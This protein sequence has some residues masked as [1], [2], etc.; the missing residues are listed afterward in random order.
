MEIK[1]IFILLIIILNILV[2]QPETA[3]ARGIIIADDRGILETFRDDNQN[4]ILD[5]AQAVSEYEQVILHLGAQKVFS[6]G[7]PF[8]SRNSQNNLVLFA[9]EMQKQDQNFYLWFMD[10]FGSEMFLELYDNYQEIIDANYNGLQDLNLVYDGIVI[11]LEWINL[12]Q[13]NSQANNSEKY[14]DILKYLNKKFEDKEIYA[15]MSIVDD[16]E[17]NFK[18]GYKEDEILRYLDNIIPMLYIKDGGSYLAEAELEMQLKENRIES[19]RKYYQN[20]N[21]QAAVSLEGGIYLEK[22]KNLYF[23]KTLKYFDYQDQTELLYSRE[24]KYYKIT[25]YQP[26]ENFTIERN[27]GKLIE[28]KEDELLHF[29]EIK[30]ETLVKEDDYIWEYFQL[31]Q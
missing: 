8:Y 20:R 11:D 24:K 30:A 25:G 10:S 26:K 14:L 6:R 18:R 16:Q 21:Y 3:A 4:K 7:H 27:D 29:L 2:I 9:E 5:L 12:G 22:N 13:E 23:I 15:F 1:I 31:Q 17:E 28:I 19:L